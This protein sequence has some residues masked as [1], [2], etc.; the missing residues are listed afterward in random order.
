MG[1]RLLTALHDRLRTPGV[2]FNPLA[3]RKVLE[4]LGDLHRTAPRPTKKP[5]KDWHLDMH[6]DHSKISTSGEPSL[7]C[8]SVWRG[9]VSDRESTGP[10]F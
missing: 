4:H 1:G 5:M 10:G 9:L 6:M 3:A 7:T 8:V 2:A